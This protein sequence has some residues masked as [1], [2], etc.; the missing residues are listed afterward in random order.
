MHLCQPG[1]PRLSGLEP[2]EFTGRLAT[3]FVH[4]DDRDRV[5]DRLGQQFQ[6]LSGSTLVQFRMGTD[7]DH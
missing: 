7:G 3:D 6:A 1:H 2:D 5:R 4:P